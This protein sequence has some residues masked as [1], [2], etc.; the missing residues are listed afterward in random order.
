MDNL[1][2]AFEDNQPGFPKKKKVKPPSQPKGQATGPGVGE[3]KGW[4]VG[5]STPVLH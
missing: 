4:N 3:K 1:A 2:P 5:W